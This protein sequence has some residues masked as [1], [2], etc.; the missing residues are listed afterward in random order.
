MYSPRPIIK[1]MIMTNLPFLIMT[2]PRVGFKCGLANKYGLG[3]LNIF[4]FSIALDSHTVV[5]DKLF[6]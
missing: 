2:A 6:M 1:R 4:L 3:G 5:F